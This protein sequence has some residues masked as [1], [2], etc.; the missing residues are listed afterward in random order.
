MRPLPRE[1]TDALDATGIPWTV[2]TNGGKT[3]IKLDGAL[4]GVV[5]AGS[6]KSCNTTAIQ[7]V[8]A[9]IRRAAK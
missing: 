9:Q 4:V 1:I 7:N 5:P 2:Q 3:K 8:L 6:R